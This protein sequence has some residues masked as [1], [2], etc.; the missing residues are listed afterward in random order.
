MVWYSSWISFHRPS[1][2]LRTP[3]LSARTSRQSVPEFLGCGVVAVGDDAANSSRSLLILAPKFKEVTTCPYI[4]KGYSASARSPLASS[5]LP[6]LF[7]TR[8]TRCHEPELLVPPPAILPPRIRGARSTMSRSSM[9]TVLVRVVARTS[10]AYAL[11]LTAA[12]TERVKL[13]V[14]TANR[15]TTSATPAPS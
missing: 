5:E 1:P 10:G 2:Y 15:R 11:F 3:S 9:L 6:S 12:W 8:G 7:S 14:G 13:L 4:R